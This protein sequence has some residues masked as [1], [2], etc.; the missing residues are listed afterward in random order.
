MAQAW[1]PGVSMR[2]PPTLPPLPP[3]YP[4]HY[5]KKRRL[6]EGTLKILKQQSESLSNST[7]EIL[8]NQNDIFSAYE[9]EVS[10]LKN[11]LTTVEEQLRQSHQQINNQ[12]YQIQMNTKNVDNIRATLNETKLENYSLK[13]QIDELQMRI[14]AEMTSKEES[15]AY[16]KNLVKGLQKTA[17]N[18]EEAS[19]YMRKLHKLFDDYANGE[20]VADTEKKTD[21]ICA[22]CMSEPANIVAKPCH[23]LE[24]CLSCAIEQFKFKENAFST[25]KSVVVENETDCPRCKQSIAYVDYVYL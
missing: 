22:I 10:F 9:N 19:C 23:H 5:T 24:W 8:Q 12:S 14:L 18:A 3:V 1:V 13:T 4:I 20:A 16:Y 17:A 2:P 7:T 21:R 11:K 6:Q 25:S 15:V